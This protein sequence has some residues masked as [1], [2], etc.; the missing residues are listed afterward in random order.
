M[1]K[2]TCR[3]GYQHNLTPCPDDGWITV[4]DRDYQQLLE[5]EAAQRDNSSVGVPAFQLQGRLYECPACGRLMW[6]R[7][8]DRC[9]NFEVFNRE[10]CGRN[11]NPDHNT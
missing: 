6:S 1:P 9:S 10:D 4:R 2:V 8:G 3:C 5:V 11:S 7:P